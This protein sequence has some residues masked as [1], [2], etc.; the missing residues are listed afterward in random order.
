MFEKE[1]ERMTLF[2]IVLNEFYR[3]YVASFYPLTITCICIPICER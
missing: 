3:S 1:A 2:F